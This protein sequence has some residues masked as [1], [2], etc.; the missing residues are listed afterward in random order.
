MPDVATLNI[1]E[2]APEFTAHQD[3]GGTFRLTEHQGGWVLLF[4][5]PR[6]ST[7]YCQMQARRFQ[8]LQPDYS[9][10][11]VQVVGIS[12]DTAQQQTVFRDSCQLD[13]PLITDTD[14]RVG[15]RYG[16]MET[17]R[18]DGEAALRARRESFLIDP[19][20]RLVRHYT[21]VAANTHAA[22]VLADLQHLIPS[23]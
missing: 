4:F 6:A 19:Q 23:A 21:E 20:G 8:A 14:H 9:R 7:S 22:E 16:V 15:T 12:S 10:L 1:G 5:F 17:E 3:R 13:F 18:V 2:L 11:G